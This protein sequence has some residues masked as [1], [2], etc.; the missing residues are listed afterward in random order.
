MRQCSPSSG[1]AARPSPSFFPP[2]HFLTNIP[3]PAPSRHIPVPLSQS[4][5]TFLPHSAT[6]ALQ[7]LER[8]SVSASLG[9]CTQALS[10]SFERGFRRLGRDLM[11]PGDAPAAAGRPRDPLRLGFRFGEL[12]AGARA[13]RADVYWFPVG[14]HLLRASGRLR[15]A[16]V[17]QLRGGL[18][19]HR[20]LTVPCS[21]T[22]SRPRAAKAC[23]PIC[24][25]ALMTRLPR[26]SGPV[27]R[28]QVCGA[29]AGGLRAVAH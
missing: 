14:F 11:T 29:R 18:A 21:R 27:S 6:A 7:D 3:F 19:R 5:P 15:L 20:P 12:P 13:G 1:C 22:I 8:R 10:L 26:E 24:T 9:K 2:P 23:I 16:A 17:R 28:T 25:N 4:S